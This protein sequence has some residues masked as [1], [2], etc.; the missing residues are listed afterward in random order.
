MLDIP[1]PTFRWQLLAELLDFAWSLE[2]RTT[3]R[4]AA[5][6]GGQVVGRFHPNSRRLHHH[7]EL[8]EYV[9]AAELEVLNETHGEE[10]LPRPKNPRSRDRHGRRKRRRT[11]A[12]VVRV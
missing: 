11:D 6:D 5:D 12:T 3:P 7:D 4:T 9:T 10:D 8:C 2:D 1:Q